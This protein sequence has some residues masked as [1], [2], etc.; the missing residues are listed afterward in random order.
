MRALPGPSVRD[1][2]QIMQLYKRNGTNAIK[3]TVK[4]EQICAAG[5]RKRKRLPNGNARTGLNM[6]KL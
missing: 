3:N 1:F 4:K 5:S 2:I 6:N